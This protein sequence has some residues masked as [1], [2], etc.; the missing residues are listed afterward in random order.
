[1]VD[2]GGA[3]LAPASRCCSWTRKLVSCAVPAAIVLPPLPPPPLP[4]PSPEK[5]VDG[6]SSSGTVNHSCCSNVSQSPRR[7]GSTASIT[8]RR[9]CSCGEMVSGSGY[10][11]GF[12]AMAKMI[13]VELSSPRWAHGSSPVISS[14]TEQPSAHRSDATEYRP[15][16]ASGDRYAGVPEMVWVWW[17][18][19]S[20]EMPK[21]ASLIDP[22]AP[23]SAL[24]GLISRWRMPSEWRYLRPSSIWA[25]YVRAAASQTGPNSLISF[26]SDPS[27]TSSM[28]MWMRPLSASRCMPYPRTRLRWC[29]RSMIS[30]SRS[31]LTSIASDISP[32]CS[33]FTASGSPVRTSMAEYT[34]PYAPPPM[35]RLFFHLMPLRDCAASISISAFTSSRI[36]R[37]TSGLRRSSSEYCRSALR[38]NKSF[39][40]SCLSCGHIAMHSMSTS[41]EMVK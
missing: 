29:R 38:C 40:K 10:G 22:S 35:R 6:S 34:S 14:S 18:R 30:D 37:C 15:L 9:S 2:G 27:G 33:V 32:I 24:A 28:M 7:S 23:M 4:V 31:R 1:M 41:R 11:S 19:P 16:M 5:P 21:S 13:C 3:S 8:R 12:V 17:L 20:R 39:S 26:A 36:L 25:V